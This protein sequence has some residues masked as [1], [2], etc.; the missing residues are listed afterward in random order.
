MKFSRK[1]K[2]FLYRLLPL[3]VIACCICNIYFAYRVNVESRP[4]TVFNYHEVT[5]RIDVSSNSLP[6]NMFSSVSLSSP[7]SPSDS[8]ARPSCASVCRVPYQYFLCGRRIGAYVWGRF[9]YEGS[10]CSYGR[11][12]MIFPDRIILDSGDWI[13]NARVF[14]PFDKSNRR[15]NHDGG[16]D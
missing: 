10:P 1:I 16:T 4:V 5:N 2:A 9:Y 15:L 8:V 7:D 11:I 3:S 6:S 12:S 14:D 13:E